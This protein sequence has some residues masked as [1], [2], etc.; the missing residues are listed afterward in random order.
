MNISRRM[1]LQSAGASLALTGTGI[2]Y[3]WAQSTA[4]LGEMEITTLSDGFLVQPADFVYAPMPQDDLATYLATRGIARDASLTPP[5]NITLLRHQDRLVL[6]D[7]GSGTGFVPT[8]GDLPDALDAAGIDPG[9]ITHVVFTHAHADH[10]WGVLDDFDDPFFYNAQHLM[11]RA[12]FDYWNNPETVNAV[13]ESRVSMAVGA[14]R[15]LGVLAESITLFDDGQEIIPGIAARA[16]YGHTPGH[17]GF[18]LRSGS[19]SAM[20]VGDALINDHTAFA[21]PDW[22]IGADADQA[23]AAQ[24]RRSLLDQLAHEQITM[25]GFHLP[26][27]GLG[28]VERSD[29]AFRFAPQEG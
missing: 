19:Q 3:G 1:L 25:V 20:V 6:F 22:P 21:H 15:R 28:Q 11:G 27:G 26:Q 17:M 18:E 12:E 9:D 2:R 24:T 7:A 5:C 4:T 23:Q 14:A 10:L 8:A 29:G 16:T 13:P